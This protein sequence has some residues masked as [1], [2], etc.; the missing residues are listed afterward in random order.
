MCSRRATLHRRLGGAARAQAPT[1]K[2]GLAEDKTPHW[3]RV[4]SVA[5]E[6]FPEGVASNLD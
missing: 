2:A 4:D 5:C 6:V 3:A 1:E